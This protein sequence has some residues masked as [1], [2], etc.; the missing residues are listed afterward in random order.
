VLGA[1]A[2]AAAALLPAALS[3]QAIV[4][5]SALPAY[6]LVQVSVPAGTVDADEF[7]ARTEAIRSCNEAGELARRLDGEFRRNR[8]VLAGELPRPVQD[9]LKELPVGQATQVFGDGGVMRVL[10]ICNRL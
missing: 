3:A 9:A 10:V 8:R 7:R 1:S 5:S 2:L 6:H 4:R